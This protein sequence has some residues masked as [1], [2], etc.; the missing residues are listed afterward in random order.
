MRAVGREAEFPVVNASDGTAADVK[1][2]VHLAFS[3]QSQDS[4]FEL[5]RSGEGNDRSTHDDVLGMQGH[6]IEFSLEVGRGTV[7][8]ICGPCDDLHHLQQQHELGMNMLLKAAAEL[9]L[10][11]LGYGVQP[12]TP[13]S[14]DLMTHK[15]RYKQLL[16][17]MGSPWLWFTVTASDQLH[18]D[19]HQNELVAQT[20]ICN[21]LTPTVVALCGNSSVHSGKYSGFSSSREAAI[22]LGDLPGVGTTIQQRHGIPTRPFE[23]AVAYTSHVADL[24]FFMRHNFENE[25]T[26][27]SE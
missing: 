7:E 2:L 21:L 19:I 24:P 17:S 13:P 15:H 9:G 18:V 25:E 5:L 11:V 4:G 8:L 14:N 16:S 20:N 23:S 3:M 26:R 27:V 1:E 10:H 12:I 22:G 6:G